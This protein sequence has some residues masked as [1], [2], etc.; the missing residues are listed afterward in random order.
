MILISSIYSIYMLL[1]QVRHFLTFWFCYFAELAQ[2]K[3]TPTDA[4]LAVQ[5]DKTESEVR[6][7]RPPSTALLFRL[8]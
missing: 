5:I 8:A 1:N 7:H 2:I 6:L 3:S 4:E